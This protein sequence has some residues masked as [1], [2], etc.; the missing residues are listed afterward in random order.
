MIV[1]YIYVELLLDRLSTCVLKHESE[2]PR[3][4]LVVSAKALFGSM[5][6]TSSVSSLS[7]AS[8]GK[9]MNMKE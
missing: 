8:M 9:L 7:L 4:K 1:Q 6:P 2:N 5:N 3:I